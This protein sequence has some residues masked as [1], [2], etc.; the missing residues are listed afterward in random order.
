V[1][2]RS[3]SA[4]GRVVRAASA[5]PQRDVSRG[6]VRDELRDE[7]RR[8]PTEVARR[9][10]QIGLLE[11]R[12][13]AHADA[14]DDTGPLR[15]GHR[16]R[17]PRVLDRHLRRRERVLD[18]DVHLLQVLALD[19]ALGLEVPHLARD[20][21]RQARRIEARDRSDT[22][23]TRDEL[24]P[25][26]LDTAAERGD[27]AEAGHRDAPARVIRRAQGRHD[28]KGSRGCQGCAVSVPMPAAQRPT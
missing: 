25:V 1:R 4:R 28:R 6:H 21:R 24:R 19:V 9:E 27:Q 14:D 5:D 7:E 22:G 13:T 11:A 2:P 17:Q 3:A 12:D 18:E 10:Q 16:R 23:A 8:H 15:Y 26:G 20:A